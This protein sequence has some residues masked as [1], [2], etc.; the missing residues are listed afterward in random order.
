MNEKTMRRA[1]L[2]ITVLLLASVGVWAPQQ[3]EVILFKICLVT[4]AALLGYWVDRVIF[5]Y[6]RL[7]ELKDEMKSSQNN[8]KSND[9]N[10]RIEDA[11]NKTSSF[12]SGQ[13]RRAIIIFGTILGVCLGL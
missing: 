7:H 12:N 1:A 5:P 6:G 2:V 4:L 8:S 11:K 9:K 13:I 3:V 10:A